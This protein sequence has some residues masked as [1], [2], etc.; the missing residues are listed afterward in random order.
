V[1][2]KLVQLNYTF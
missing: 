1:K 2:I